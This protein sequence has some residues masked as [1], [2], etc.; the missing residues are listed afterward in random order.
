[1]M[2]LTFCLGFSNQKNFVHLFEELWKKLLDS[3]KET[4]KLKALKPPYKFIDS[5][6]V[7]LELPCEV[8]LILFP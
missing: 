3:I 2:T 6:E 1:M 7:Q 8:V 4:K 5:P